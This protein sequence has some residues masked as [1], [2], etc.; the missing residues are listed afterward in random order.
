MIPFLY[1]FGAKESYE[2]YILVIRGQLWPQRSYKGHLRSL[3]AIFQFS[4]LFLYFEKVKIYFSWYIHIYVFSSFHWW[5]SFYFYDHS[6]ILLEF[7]KLTSIYT[8]FNRTNNHGSFIYYV[9]AREFVLNL[10]WKIVWKTSHKIKT[11]NYGR[12]FQNSFFYL[13]IYWNKSEL[14]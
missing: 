9:I 10:N 4:A 3:S 14:C 8:M 7:I 5:Y 11:H 13:E 2:I 6:S 1:A 12:I